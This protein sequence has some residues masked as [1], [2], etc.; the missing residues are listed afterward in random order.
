VLG[1]AAL[2][3][4]QGAN[5]P[6]PPGVR[7]QTTSSSFSFTSA[8]ASRN[9]VGSLGTVVARWRSS[10]IGAEIYRD[11]ARSCARAGARSPS[12]SR[13]APRRACA[14]GRVWLFA[15]AA[16]RL[17]LGR[18][19]LEMSV[20]TARHS[21]TSHGQA[22]LAAA[23]TSTSFLGPRARSSSACTRTH[24]TRLSTTPTRPSSACD[25]PDPAKSASAERRIRAT[26]RDQLACSAR[27]EPSRAEP[28]RQRVVA[29]GRGCLL[30]RTRCVVVARALL[31]RCTRGR[32]DLLLR[33]REE[34]T[35]GGGAMQSVQRS[36]L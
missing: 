2:D 9:S 26:P 29:D 6:S 30:A 10:L 13:V 18:V 28:G 36:A 17:G 24:Q 7:P 5:A 20:P 4:V 1:S 32:C 16:A 35:S 22:S 34:K 33:A 3:I 25:L 14:R 8:F 19:F 23:S 11:P 21:N 31:L 15:L 27:C 12:T